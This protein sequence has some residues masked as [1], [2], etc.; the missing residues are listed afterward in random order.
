MDAEILLNVKEVAQRL[1]ISVPTVYDWA[2]K[3]ILPHIRLSDRV[4]RFRETD[5]EKYKTRRT[6]GRP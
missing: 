6:K 1:R 4:L 3:G 5:I 2:A